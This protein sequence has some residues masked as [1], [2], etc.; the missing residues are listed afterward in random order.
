M[1]QD[2]DK[3]T[4]SISEV[5]GFKYILKNG[6]KYF[7]GDFI[8]VYDQEAKYRIE[9]ILV[10]DVFSPDRFKA[11]SRNQPAFIYRL[12]QLNDFYYK[13]DIKKY[14][15]AKSVRM[16]ESAL[17]EEIHD[18]YGNVGKLR[19]MI[20]VDG[21]L[22]LK[23]LCTKIHNSNQEGDFK[24]VL[25]KDIEVRGYKRCEINGLYYHQNFMTLS[26]ILNLETGTLTRILVNRDS[27]RAT[28][29]VYLKTLY[30]LGYHNVPNKSTSISLVNSQ[31][32][33]EK[34]QDLLV[35][36]PRSGMLILKSEINRDGYRQYE[37]GYYFPEFKNIKKLKPGNTSFNYK[38]G[39]D[40]NTHL[41]TEGLKYTFGVE[42]EMADCIFTESLLHD[43]NIFVEKDGSIKNTRGEKYGP[44]VVTGILKGDK[45]FEH[46][47]ALCNELARNSEV[48]T[49]CGLHVHIGSADFNNNN[50][51]MLFKLLKYVENDVFAMLPKSRST[52]EFCRRLPDFDFN[53][54]NCTSLMDLKIRVNN[55]YTELF[56]KA[57]NTPP[58]DKF[59]KN[60][61]HPRG[62]KVGYDHSNIRYCW[63]NFIPAM[64]NTRESTPPSYTIEFRAFNGTTNFNKVKNWVKICMALVNFAENYHS[65]IMSNS[66]TLNDGVVV[67][68]TLQ[69]VMQKVYPKSYRKLNEFITMRTE[70]F[71]KSNSQEDTSDE[72]QSNTIS[73][74]K[75]KELI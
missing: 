41:I 21:K 58:N 45:G 9:D 26:N 69:N 44:E 19:D 55:Y 28:T 40:S 10:K 25:T 54:D 3:N 31:Q 22:V 71:K 74:L 46:L 37:N 6:I 72:Q 61:N 53:F 38:Y 48:N 16:Y 7:I 18:S 51:V 30:M 34:Y 43:F 67:S 57:A 14:K 8:R 64:F 65:D 4:Y 29:K 70:L 75:I 35:I 56:T 42:L 32:V 12:E 73:N 60:H 11:S 52:N 49:T 15:H 68:L 1:S 24:Y 66:V 62:A 2:K 36:G 17:N 39:L 13:K 63:A 47:Q 59:N 33:L 50:L 5:N 20:Q 27:E 23:K